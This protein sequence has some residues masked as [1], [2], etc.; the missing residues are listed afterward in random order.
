MEYDCFAAKELTPLSVSLGPRPAL[1]FLG[2]FDDILDMASHIE[3]LGDDERA[4][5]LT[6]AQVAVQYSSGEVPP[7][8]R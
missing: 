5:M 4:I 6:A 7:C 8:H 2:D 3:Q 1:S